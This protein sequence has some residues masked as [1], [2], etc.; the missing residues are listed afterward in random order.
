[1]ASIAVSSLKRGPEARECAMSILNA[2][3]TIL[4]RL[5][6]LLSR[7][8]IVILGSSGAIGSFLKQ[9]LLHRVEPGNLYGVDIA[10]ADYSNREIPEF[11]TIEELGEEALRN[12]EM[13]IGV[14][15]SSIL[16][17]KHIE[18]IILHGRQKSILFISGSTKTLEF[19]D[20]QDFLQSLC[21]EKNKKIGDKEINVDFNELRDL[22]TGIFQGYQVEISCSSD[23]A[24]NKLFYLL[25]ALMPINFLYYGIPR[26]I[27]DEVMAQLFRLSCGFV[28][29]QQSE[30]KLQP[31]LLAVDHEIDADAHSLIPGVTGRT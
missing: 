3:E 13:F 10:A 4:N 22:Q 24:I 1:V 25:G 26:E 31:L 23:P 5:G 6:I 20:L 2:T 16:K 17:Q 15:G 21:D 18:E 11:K 29:R 28:K 12:T 9:E 14:I 8:K 19:S 7:R 30:D 27:V